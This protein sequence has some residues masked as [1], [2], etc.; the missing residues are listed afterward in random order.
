MFDI[1]CKSLL[2]APSI[3]SMPPALHIQYSA[4]ISAHLFSCTVIP[5]G[6]L[7]V[8]WFK[9]TYLLSPVYSHVCFH[10]ATPSPSSSNCDS[11][12]VSSQWSRPWVAV[13]GTLPLCGMLGNM[14]NVFWWTDR[15]NP[16]GAEPFNSALQ[17]FPP[18]ALTDTSSFALYAP[19][20]HI[21]LKFLSKMLEFF[22]FLYHLS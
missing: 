11:V 6:L 5:G 21:S 16:P 1:L 18:S 17:L 19:P 4:L 8:K 13:R 15:P 20:S 12:N 14:C 9:N 2:W 7:N 3:L 22:A 10:T